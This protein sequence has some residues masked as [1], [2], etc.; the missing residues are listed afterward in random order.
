[1]MLFLYSQLFFEASEPETWLP[2]QDI[3]EDIATVPEVFVAK[4]EQL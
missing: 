4:H 1:M 3:P 2:T